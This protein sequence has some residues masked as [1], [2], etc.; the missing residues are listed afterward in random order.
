MYITLCLVDLTYGSQLED[1]TEDNTLCKRPIA[2]NKIY[3]YVYSHMWSSEKVS[4]ILTAV[5][6][7]RTDDTRVQNLRLIF[8]KV[9]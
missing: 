1:G 6:V 7:F 2:Q 3:S 5:C 8:G 9:L 4:G